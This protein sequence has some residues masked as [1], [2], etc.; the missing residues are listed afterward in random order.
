MEA[1]EELGFVP[2]FNCTYSPKYNPIEVIFS[3]VKRRYK[4]QRLNKIVNDKPF[5]ED[6]LIRRAFGQVSS[7]NILK[8][9]HSSLTLL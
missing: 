6:D 9:V 1:Y 5:S 3:Q 4:E 2:V 8:A 7:E